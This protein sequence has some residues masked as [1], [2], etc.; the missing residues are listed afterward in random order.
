MRWLPPEATYSQALS[1]SSS[2]MPMPR[3]KSTGKSCCCADRLEQ[4]EVLR[5]ARADL[6]HHAGRIARRCERVADLVDVRLVRHLHGDDRMPYLP[7]SSN[8][9]GRQAAPWPWKSYGLVR[10]L[11]APARVVTMPCSASARKV[12][13]TFSRV[14][15]GAQAREDVQRVLREGDAVV[16]EAER[17]ELAVVAADGAE[18]LGDA[19]DLLDALE[20]LERRRRHGVRR[21]R[22]GRPR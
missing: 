11:Y 9:Y 2:V 16:L 7:A 17:L 22:A 10:G 18:L 6:Q 4:L 14:V 3:L 12:A 13:S 15:D 8:T 21:R 20:L 5:V 1:D 19:H